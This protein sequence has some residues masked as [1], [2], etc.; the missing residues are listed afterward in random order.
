MQQWL[1]VLPLAGSLV[2]LAA[3][4]TSLCATI[5]DRRKCQ[6]ETTNVAKD[7]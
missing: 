4:I 7:Q 2:N 6:R 5:L 1:D 3:A